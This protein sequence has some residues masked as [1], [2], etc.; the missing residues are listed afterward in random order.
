MWTIPVPASDIVSLVFGGLD[1][2]ILFVGTTNKLLLN[3]NKEAGAGAIFGISGLGATGIPDNEI[4]I[5]EQYH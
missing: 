2:K 1:K 4:V 3:S 5:P